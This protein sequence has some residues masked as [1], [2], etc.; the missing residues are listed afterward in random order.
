MSQDDRMQ[1]LWQFYAL[2]RNSD[3][4]LLPFQSRPHEWSRP[5]VSRV[6]Y[7]A[8][9]EGLGFSAITAETAD[10][11]SPF[12]HE[13]VKVEQSDDEN[14]PITVLD[15]VW[16]GFRF[17]EMLFSRCGVIVYGGSQ[18]IR[19][20][21]AESSTLYFTHRRLNRP[22]NDLSMGWGSNS[23]WRTSIRLEYECAN[24]LFYN[25][26]GKDALTLTTDAAS[27]RNGLTAEERLE[28]CRNRS[29]IRTAR[30]DHDLWPFDDR[31]VERIDRAFR[32]NA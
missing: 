5:A 8:F 14:E 3:Y 23:Q 15:C 24:Q 17:G 11:F 18:H 9:F 32:S 6:E 16:P 31:Y 30:P 22:T 21:V 1:C 13:V 12:H 29:F 26:D 19:K 10:S 4:L 27:D 2:S 28:L 20:G 7:V 25:V